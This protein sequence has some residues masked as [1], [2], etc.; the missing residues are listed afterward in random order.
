MPMKTKKALTIA[1]SLFLVLMLASAAFA[2]PKEDRPDPMAGRIGIGIAA[3]LINSP[4]GSGFYGQPSFTYWWNRYFS[5]T[6]ALGYGFYS[7]EYVD[8][9][10]ETQS[11]TV[12]F[13]P[14]ELLATVYVAPGKKINP[15]LGPGVGFDYITYTLEDYT[16]PGDDEDVSMTIYSGIARAGVWYRMAR[17]VG[18]IAGGR[19]THPL[20]KSDDLEQQ[21]G[22]TFTLELGLSMFF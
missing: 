8:Y 1:I 14:G 11:T 10:G 15:Y 16:G 22:G 6:I 19:Y 21:G 13:V 20:N 7:A 2:A 3:S 18:L 5:N 9:E 12:S 4:A 17:N